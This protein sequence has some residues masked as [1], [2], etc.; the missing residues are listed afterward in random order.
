MA[1]INPP[2]L[3]GASHQRTVLIGTS[4][5]QSLLLPNPALKVVHVGRHRSLVALP[6]PNLG[7]LPHRRWENWTFLCIPLHEASFHSKMDGVPLTRGKGMRSTYLKVA[8]ALASLRTSWPHARYHNLSQN[9]HNETWWLESWGNAMLYSQITC[10][11]RTTPRHK[12]CGCFLVRFF[13]VLQLLPHINQ[14][15]C[16]ISESTIKHL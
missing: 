11:G 8:F 7:H 12:V 13:H 15:L 4:C 5:N 9:V 16:C 14:Y 1:V 10:M 6:V 3:T 2:T